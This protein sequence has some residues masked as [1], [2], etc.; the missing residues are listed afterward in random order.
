MGEAGMYGG[1]IVLR[2]GWQGL[3]NGMQDD[4]CKRIDF[5]FNF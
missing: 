2:K 4:N 3:V 1:W 5:R